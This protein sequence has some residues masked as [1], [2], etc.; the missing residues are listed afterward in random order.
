MG[1][2]QAEKADEAGGEPRAAESGFRALRR[3]IVPVLR[4]GVREIVLDRPTLTVGRSAVCEVQL[5]SALVSRRHARLTLTNLGVTVE[6]LGSRNGVYVNSVRVI[7]SARL[8]PGDRLAIGDE[9][10]VFA[11]LTEPE[12]DEPRSGTGHSAPAPRDTF[13]DDQI[14][15]A[16]RSA[17][18]FQ[19]LAGVVDKA[20]ALGR[21]E[22]A[23][24][25]IATHL[26]AALADAESGR[27]VSSDI[28]RTAAGYAVKLAGATG[29]AAWLDH[30][31]KLYDALGLVLPL[32]LV[33]EMYVL[34]RR[35]RG[36]D[37]DV[38]KTY[39]E[40][41]RERNQELAPAE[42]FVLQRLLGLERL[43][44]WQTSAGL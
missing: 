37:L 31:V 8:K 42:R 27:E 10:L 38:L 39:T 43:A 30:A 6:D 12:R 7:G 25:V 22:E 40:H 34:L 4:Q 33:D 13:N 23:E 24:R 17:D 19:L 3:R 32:A 28:A 41:L 21:G 9:L 20:L 44:S 29:K 15:V 1:T 18:V 5:S 26:H 11:E 14:A 2:E 36:L 35:V 16:T